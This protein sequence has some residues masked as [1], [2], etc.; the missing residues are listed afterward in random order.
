MILG[1]ASE[2]SIARRAEWLHRSCKMV[3]GRLGLG[4][5]VAGELPKTGLIASNHLS[6]LDIL[7]YGATLPCVFVAKT[8]VREWPLLGLLAA[9]GGTVFIDRRSAASAA[10]AAVRIE[11]MLG[12]GVLVRVFPEGTSSDGAGV[13][14]FYSSLFEPAV[15]VGAPVTA[16]AIGYSAGAEAEERDLCYYGDISFAP[17]LLETLQLLEILAT[18]RFAPSGKRYD[19][20][21]K[22]AMLTREDVVELRLAPKFVAERKQVQG[23]GSES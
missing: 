21:K 20:R 18:L 16:A 11:E 14:R 23:K 9:L 6:Y 13:L 15:R 22:A 7:F 12:A 4:I 10:A 8:E 19:D 17:H 1:V 3:L 2:P 5:R